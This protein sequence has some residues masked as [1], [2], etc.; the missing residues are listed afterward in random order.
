[1]SQ[2]L[3]KHSLITVVLWALC[4]LA[5]TCVWKVMMLISLQIGKDIWA[6]TVHT[7]FLQI[8]IWVS[9]LTML[10]YW[11]QMTNQKQ[12]SYH[13]DP[14]FSDRYAWVYTVCYSVCIV[15]THYSMVVPHSSNFRV[16]TTNILGIR[17]FRKI[18]IF[19]LSDDQSEAEFLPIAASSGDYRQE[20]ARRTQK[21][22]RNTCSLCGK[23]FDRQSALVLH[24]RIHTGEKPYSCEICGKSFTQKGHLRRHQL[25][26]RSTTC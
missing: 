6:F 13:N 18:T 26:H 9:A 5:R 4:R 10:Y 16:I 3:S 2:G 19:L 24:E 21:L 20:I 12:S 1:M 25:I 14:K 8:F 15:W 23:S 11:F 17:I 22:L 7:Y